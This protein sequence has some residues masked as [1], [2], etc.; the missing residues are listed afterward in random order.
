ML[1]GTLVVPNAGR[2]F[3]RSDGTWG[4]PMI[5]LLFLSSALIVVSALGGWADLFALGCVSTIVSLIPPGVVSRRVRTVFW[6]WT[7][8]VL[9]FL[10]HSPF[11]TATGA[12]ASTWLGWPPDIFLMLVGIW[13]LPVAIW[14]LAFSRG[15]RTWLKL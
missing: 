4:T 6:V 1:A 13:L 5:P 10:L 7:T 9:L 2:H 14:P 15:F 3:G 8:G 12:V 11:A